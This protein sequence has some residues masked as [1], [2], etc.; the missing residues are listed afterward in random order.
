[1]TLEV[2]SLILWLLAI[3]AALLLALSSRLRM[4]PG[5]QTTSSLSR[6]VP[7][8]IAVVSGALVLVGLVSKTLPT[9]LVQ[10]S[11]LLLV[12]VIYLFIPRLGAIAATSVLSFWLVTMG[13]IWLFLL[14]ISHFLSGRFSPTEILLTVVIGMASL[15][16]LIAA[17]RRREGGTIITAILTIIL[18]SGLQSFA[19]WLSYQPIVRRR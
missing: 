17:Y 13:A 7:T 12:L 8:S 19:L 11:P 3:C 5:S 18:S 16:G 4:A 9:H 14:G 15:V 6:L 1:M 2:K 10:I